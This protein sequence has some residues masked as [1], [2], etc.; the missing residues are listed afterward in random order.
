MGW[1]SFLHR[2]TA[3]PQAFSSGLS[4]LAFV[5]A[6]GQ[7]HLIAGNM[8]ATA[9]SSWTLGTGLTHRAQVTLPPGQGLPLPTVLAPWEDGTDSLIWAG[10]MGGAGAALYRVTETGQMQPLT[11]LRPQAGSVVSLAPASVGSTALVFTAARGSDSITAWQRQGDGSFT[12]TENLRLIPDGPG[13]D[14]LALAIAQ[15]GGETW[16]LAASNQDH[17]LTSFRITPQGTLDRTARLGADGGLGV[18]QPTHLQTVTFQGDTYAIMGAAGTSSVSVIRL[19]PDGALVVTDQVNDTL[20]TRFQGVTALTV[21]ESQGRVYVIAAGSDDGLTVMTLLPGGRLVGLDTAAHVA[22]QGLSNPTALTA[23][24]TE[25][26]DI[27]VYAA[28]QGSGLPAGYVI[29]ADIAGGQILT[30]AVSGGALAGTAGDDILLGGPGNDN[31]RGEAGRDILLDGPGRDTMFGGP[32]ADL[33]VLIADGETDRIQDFEAGIDR[34][35]LSDMTRHASPDAITFQ[36]QANGIRLIVGGETVQI[37]TANG[38]PLTRQDFDTADLFDLWHIDTSVAVAGRILDGGNGAETLTGG[39]GDDIL[40]GSGGN[41]TLRGDMGHDLL[42]GGPGAD[43]LEGGPGTDTA[44]YTGSVGSL[45]VDLLFPQINTNIAAGDTFLSIENLIGSQDMDNLRGTQ[46]PNRIQGMANVDYIFGRQGDDTL[47]GGVGDDVLFGGPGADV[48]IGGPNRD[49]AQYS[50]SLTPL[51][52][53]LFDP[54]RNTG[55]AAGDI[56]L[57]VEDLAGGR[58]NDT[59]VG[60]NGANR[61]FGREGQDHLFGR[62]GNDILNGGAHAD[63][64]DGGPGNDTLRGGTH[65]DTFVFNGGRDVIEDFTFTHADR[66]AIDR[67]V[68]PDGPALSPAQVVAAFARVTGGQVVFDFFDGNQLVLQNLSS[69]AGLGDVVILI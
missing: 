20:D 34:L 68:L 36:P 61:L 57:S 67:D 40:H 60:D 42:N 52:V 50:E 43:R 44:D 7:T 32:G 16:L 25:T 23:H 46:G 54:A 65:N 47:D 5:T 39:P 9:L 24:V 69:T 59:I 56:Y 4:D 55:E 27:R 30:A 10:G 22:G 58:F 17:S 41:D 66:I 12:Q 18:A 6:G 3:V 13:H 1:I 53:D 2:L 48:L 29:D 37:V 21:A 8:G 38:Q 45:R 26:G 15:A 51:L 62:G 14:H 35:D 31:L 19:D 33:F 11:G 63:R 49:R 28:D 64:L